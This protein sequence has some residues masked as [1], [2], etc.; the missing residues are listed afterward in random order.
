MSA[1][2]I[3]AGYVLPANPMYIDFPVSDGDQS[4]WPTNT[5]RV[6]DTEG[7]VN[8]MRPVPIDESLS[9]KW[10]CEV[11]SSLATQLKKPGQS[12]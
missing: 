8:Y 1:R 2:G 9:I 6:V 7:H 11:G 10:R 3:S 5:D 12:S 4:Q